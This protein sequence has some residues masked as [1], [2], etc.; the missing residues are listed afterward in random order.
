MG[1]GHSH[2]HGHGHSHGRAGERHRRPLAIALALVI[3]YLGVQVVV[4]LLTGSLTL[5][6][7][8]GH[9]ATDALGLGL[10]LVAIRA[11]SRPVADSSRTFGSFRLEILAALANA[12]LLFAVAGYVLVEAALRL[13]DPPEVAS[14]QVLVVGAVGL[15]VNV[16]SFLLLREGAGESLNVRGA[17]M[18][19]MADLLGSVG[20]ILAAGGMWLT[21][22]RWI[23]PVI[24]AGIGVFIL[25]RAARLGKEALRVLLQQAPA[26]LDVEEMRADLA[27]LDGVTDVH[28]VHLWTLTSDMEVLTAHLVHERT[29]DGHGVLDAARDLL[30]QRYGVHH[31][32][33]QVEPDD[34][35]GCDQVDW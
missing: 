6:S 13:G 27:A 7:D 20:V 26:H 32:T 11:A 19:V 14:L 3:G 35:R 23:D 17:Y 28:D 30:Q 1:A 5:L 12:V 4:G 18:E 2:A 24:G 15:A 29:V 34:H 22:W 16:V 25:P 33:L 31:A 8:A 9:M 10:A 21:G